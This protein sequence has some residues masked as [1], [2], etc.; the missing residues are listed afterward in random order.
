MLTEW[1]ESIFRDFKTFLWHK[2]LWSFSLFCRP[3]FSG[4][5]FSE[6]RAF[7]SKPY[8]IATVPGWISTQRLAVPHVIGARS[9]QIG[10][11]QE[12]IWE[13]VQAEAGGEGADE[14]V[15]TP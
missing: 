6:V 5:L 11:L 9:A 2:L 1:V 8:L 14:A 13:S 12:Q 3:I 15:E 10:P 7:L 4:Y